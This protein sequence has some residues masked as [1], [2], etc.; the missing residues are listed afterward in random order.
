MTPFD[1]KNF[2]PF[3]KKFERGLTCAQINIT[4]VKIATPH[5]F[6]IPKTGDSRQAGVLLT[7]AA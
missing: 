3:Y 4:H 1:D 5:F 6:S 2:L 7:A